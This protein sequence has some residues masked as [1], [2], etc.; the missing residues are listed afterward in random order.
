MSQN[1]SR[2]QR[3]ACYSSFVKFGHNTFNSPTELKWENE[4]DQNRKIYEKGLLIV[5]SGLNGDPIVINM[6]NGNMGF[7]CHDIL[8]ETEDE[9]NLEEI[10]IELNETF[11][12]FYYQSITNP[13]F[14]VDYYESCEYAQKIA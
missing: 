9:I 12:S 3:H 4:E 5:G 7:L 14:P 1:A 6:K 13:N 8:W 2:D 10:Y 11:G